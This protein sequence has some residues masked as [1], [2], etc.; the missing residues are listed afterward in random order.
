MFKKFPWFTVLATLV[1]WMLFWEVK[2][3]LSGD[4]TLFIYRWLYSDLAHAKDIEIKTYLL[5][6]EQ[7]SY[8]FAHPEKEIQQ[9]RKPALRSKNVNVVISLG[10]SIG[11]KAYGE[12]AWS[13]PGMGWNKVDVKYVAKSAKA[14]DNAVMVIPIGVYII[15]RE[16]SLPEP[17][18]VKWEKLYVYR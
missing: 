3:T 1:A 18:E 15:E 13:L 8:M 12:L 11:G 7:V 10:D 9:P 5:T 16:D 17:I 4:R 6:D 2:E 14:P